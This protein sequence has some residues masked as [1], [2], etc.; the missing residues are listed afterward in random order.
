VKVGEA[1]LRVDKELNCNMR[2][3]SKR[4]RKEQLMSREGTQSLASRHF[5]HPHQMP[6]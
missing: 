1:H 5:W 6:R 4:E 3:Q 2:E